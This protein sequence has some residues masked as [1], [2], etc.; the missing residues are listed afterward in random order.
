MKK[1]TLSGR[2]GANIGAGRPVGAKSK[3]PKT[4]RTEVFYKRCS[5]EQK[6][7]LEKLWE[8]IK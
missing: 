7:E 2:G 5:S 1:E 3:T 8:K 6:K 4:N